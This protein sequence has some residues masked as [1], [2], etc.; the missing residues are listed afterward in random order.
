MKQKIKPLCQEMLWGFTCQKGEGHTGAHENRG[1]V[2]HNQLKSRYVF[3]WSN[4][5]AA[6]NVSETF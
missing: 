2:E 1:E 6:K 4:S 3:T 5:A